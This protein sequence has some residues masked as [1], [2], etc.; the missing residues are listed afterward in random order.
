MKKS[1]SLS[2]LSNIRIGGRISILAI[3]ALSGIVITGIIAIVNFLSISAS[4]SRYSEGSHLKILTAEVGSSALNM[5]R[6]EKDFL[7]RKDMKYVKRYKIHNKNIAKLLQQMPQYT[8][9]Q[10]LLEYAEKL[11]ALAADHQAAFAQI[12][13]LYKEIG[14]TE[15]QGLEGQL[16]QHVHDIETTL[17]QQQYNPS[18]TVKM[19]MMRRHEKDFIMRQKTK[20]IDRINTRQNEFKD[21]LAKSRYSGNVK[22]KLTSELDSYIASFRAYA[23]KTGEFNRELGKLSKIYAEM[24][25]F[26]K[27]ISDHAVDILKTSSR[28]MQE[29]STTAIM[30]V[31]IISLIILAVV[32][33]ISW[34][35]ARSI[36]VPLKALQSS[37]EDILDECYDSEV[38]GQESRDELGEISRAL[39]ILRISAQKRIQLEE[40]AGQA[41]AAKEDADKQR[42]AGEKADEKQKQQKEAELKNTADRLAMAQKFEDRVGNIL[43]TV[44]NAA[45]ELNATSTSMNQSAENMR[46][47]SASAATATGKAGQNVQIVASAAEEMTVSVKEISN[48]IVNA[49]KAS[50]NALT[51]VQNASE[52]VGLMA[53]SSSKISEIILLINDIAEQTNLL[54]LNATIEAARAGDAGRGFAVVASEVKNLASQTATATEEIKAQISE[55]QKTTGDTV[56]AVDEISVTIEKLDEISSSI[57]CSVEQQEAA[58]QEISC[59]SIEAAAGAEAAGDNVK[60][61]SLIAEETE[62]AASDVLNASGE[63]STQATTLKTV[64]DEFLTEIRT[65]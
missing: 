36:T 12:S 2:A 62:N 18:L 30:L 5:R 52:R 10:K 9:D 40:E 35:L 46:N 27:Y 59:N 21:L 25:P 16:R 22:N 57:A 41:R 1:G 14:L 49:S 3:T 60:N 32:S 58:M 63:L 8:K 28:K 6:A 38:P 39:D 17:G 11:T 50:E 4:E 7:L 55:M 43:N 29:A 23:K 13:T 54:A 48:Q 61:V 33:M 31:G 34:I 19:L 15:T 26:I 51:S 64:V 45:T 44:A 47:E 56:S 53:K 42:L 65:G 24:E 20:Y 37:V